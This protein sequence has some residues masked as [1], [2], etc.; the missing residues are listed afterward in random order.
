MHWNILTN[1]VGDDA[2]LL[3]L[4]RDDLLSRVFT[5]PGLAHFR[6]ARTRTSRM[7]LEVEAPDQ[8]IDLR[9][10]RVKL[11]RVISNLLG[12]RDQIHSER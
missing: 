5:K 12:E 6:Q 7:R 8:P 1:A 9:T 10:D 11:A 4:K 2:G 3:E